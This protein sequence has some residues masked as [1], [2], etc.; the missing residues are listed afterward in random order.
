MLNIPFDIVETVE[1]VEKRM[2]IMFIGVGGGYD[3]FGAIPL[4]ESLYGNL[5]FVNSSTSKEFLF[6]ESQPD[7]FPEGI[8][9][10]NGY[11]SYS[12]GRH[13]VQLV[14]DAYLTIAKKHDIDIIIAVDGGVD[15]LMR[16][17]EEDSGTILEDFIA[18]AAISELDVPVKFLACL[19]FGTETE[20]RLNHYRVL[21]NMAAIIKDGGFIGSCSMTKDMQCYQ[22]YMDLCHAAFETTRKSHI[23]SKVISAVEGEFGDFHLFSD[24]DANIHGEAN[25]V[26]F[27]SPLS[28]IYWFFDLDTVV[29]SNLIIEKL[30]ASKTFSDAFSLFRG[31]AKWNRSKEVIPL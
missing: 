17:D 21:E 23:H 20:E 12:V 4:A 2:N 22:I 10:E 7:N 31:C 24:V 19:G 26:F 1:N 30:K 28:S 6:Q 3:I 9:P 27:I 18:L 29:E 5:V 8:L 25:K 13:G 15:S 11:K 14:K 16:G